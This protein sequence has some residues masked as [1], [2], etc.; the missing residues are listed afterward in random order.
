M[1]LA[2]I[3]PANERLDVDD[4]RGR[5]LTII[6]TTAPGRVLAYLAVVLAFSIGL[7][8][9]TRAQDRANDASR[10]ARATASALAAEVQQV[11]AYRADQLHK[12]HAQDVRSC[13]SRHKLA[14]AIRSLIGR[15]RARALEAGDARGV[16]LLDDFLTRLDGADCTSVPP[17]APANPRVGPPLGKH[18]ASVR[19]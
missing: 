6:V 17:L 13:R 18:G 16:A 9:A 8:L 3:D 14:E 15:A 4:R 2:L 12:I 7:L 11:L 5:Q 19:G 1:G 10:E